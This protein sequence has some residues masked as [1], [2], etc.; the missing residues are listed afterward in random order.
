MAQGATKSVQ[1]DT[2]GTLATNSDLL[3]PSE[4]AVRTYINSAITQ[5]IEPLELKAEMEHYNIFTDPFDNS[6]T[7]GFVKQP[8]NYYTQGVLMASTTGTTGYVV[9]SPIVLNALTAAKKDTTETSNWTA[10]NCT[11]LTTSATA[12]VGGASVSF[13]RNATGLAYI[14]YDY[15]SVAFAIPS[16]TN[17]WFWINLSS[18]TNITNVQVTLSTDAT[19]YGTNYQ[20]FTSTTDYSGANLVS[21]WNLMKFNLSTGGAA[22]GT[23][24]TSNISARFFTV[25]TNGTNTT[26]VILVNGIYFGL[27]SPTNYVPLGTEMTIFN[28][29]YVENFQIDATNT[30]VDGQITL[31]N[32]LANIYLGGFTGASFVY[33]SSMTLGNGQ[34]AIGTLDPVGNTLAGAVT[35]TQT[36]RLA[37][38][39]RSALS[40]NSI[41]AFADLYTTQV[42]PVISTNSNTQVIVSDTSDHHLNLLTGNIVHIFQTIYTDGTANFIYRGDMT[43]SSNSSN[44]SNQTTLTCSVA[45]VPSGTAVGDYAVKKNITAAY[46]V[47]TS[48]ANESY[49]NFLTITSPDGILLYPAYRNFVYD[50]FTRTVTAVAYG[51]NISMGTSELGGQLTASLITSTQSGGTNQWLIGVDG[52][53]ITTSIS[54]GAGNVDTEALWCIYNGIKLPPNVRFRFKV[55][56]DKL[57]SSAQDYIQHGGLY[58]GQTNFSTDDGIFVGLQMDQSS[59]NLTFQIKKNGIRSGTNLVTQSTGVSTLTYFWI[60]CLIIGTTL[61]VKYW[62]DG[63][64]EP[65]TY[66]YTQNISTYINSRTWSM[67]LHAGATNNA[68]NKGA[69][70]DS[71]TMDNVGPNLKYRFQA[72]NISGQKLAYKITATTETTA[73]LPFMGK[74]GIIK[75]GN[76]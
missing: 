33:R 32:T 36:L 9:W 42:Y 52:S 23:G 37:K 7:T 17:L 66:S 29:T 38:I 2:D 70:I 11:S 49:N 44:S 40:N 10:V 27:S 22:T 67:A 24:W 12:K 48:T 18:I 72:A 69:R 61:Y 14:K 59:N 47:T 21:G 1:I 13:T 43:L 57:D 19:T 56:P 30:M 60:D 46:S 53:Q 75:Q 58:I 71:F 28:G 73:M 51:N 6:L 8:N 64:T 31:T 45:G 3:V 34:A 54:I 15:G 55:S 62:A 25:G 39:F 65:A 35:T 26:A 41:L 4:K 50:T 5:K 16:N 74:I 63:T 76:T 20:T 68:H